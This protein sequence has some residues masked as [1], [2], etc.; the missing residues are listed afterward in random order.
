[1]NKQIKEK[2]KDRTMKYVLASLGLFVPY[3]FYV[4]G[5]FIGFWREASGE[6]F[7]AIVL[8]V[9]PILLFFMGGIIVWITKIEN[10]GKQAFAVGLFVSLFGVGIL[11][12]LGIM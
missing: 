11:V 12:W 10:K 6:G 9:I 3:I 7:F 2:L 8:L 5:L 1:M 4:I